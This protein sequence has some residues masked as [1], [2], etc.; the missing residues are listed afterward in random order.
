MFDGRWT[1]DRSRLMT[2]QLDGAHPYHAAWRHQGTLIM[3]GDIKLILLRSSSS[4]KQ[5]IQ[6]NPCFRKAVRITAP[7]RVAGAL[8]R[9]RVR[10]RLER[11]QVSHSANSISAPAR[12][13]M[14]IYLR[15]Q[16][17]NYK[18]FT[19]Q[20]CTTIV[21]IGVII[22]SYQGC[23]VQM[24]GRFAPRGMASAFRFNLRCS[25]LDEWPTLNKLCEECK[26]GRF[27]GFLFNSRHVSALNGF[28]STAPSLAIY[29]S[30]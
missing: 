30:T 21:S 28:S 22:M 27:S 9:P 14:Y 10:R 12:K 16:V 15:K 6:H 26:R 18:G 13:N 19:S 7:L 4:V 2:V 20:T 11:R 24:A 29:W 17:Y 1:L 5:R 25:W 8:R 23:A 3:A